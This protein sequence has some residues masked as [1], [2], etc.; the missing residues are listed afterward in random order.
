[1]WETKGVLASDPGVLQGSLSSDGK[2][3]TISA[4]NKLDGSYGINLSSKIKTQDGIALEEHYKIISY[5]DDI[6]PSITGFELDDT[7]MIATIDF[8]EAVD[9]R[10]FRVSD[11]K[12]LLSQG[13]TTADPSTLTILRNKLN[14]VQSEDKKS[15]SINLSKIASADYNKSFLVTFA[16]IE[17]LSGNIPDSYTLTTIIKTD[18][19][20]KAQARIINV[21]RTSYD[22]ITVT[23][24]RE[25]AI[26]DGLWL[27]KVA[28]WMV[29]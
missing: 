26:L 12:L 29:K 9:L 24:D 11:V 1:M 8:N 10:N 21:R 5:V 19:T 15:I 3:F 6:P 25:L 7:G 18:T 2:T 17:D 28:L 22:R 16:G 4:S 23:F 14:Y 20:P 27:D 13:T